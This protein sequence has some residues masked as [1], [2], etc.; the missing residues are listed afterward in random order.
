MCD[1]YRRETVFL[2]DRRRL[3]ISLRSQTEPIRVVLLSG[4]EGAGSTR[5]RFMLGSG[6]STQCRKIVYFQSFE[7]R[8][9]LCIYLPSV[10]LQKNINLKN[11]ESV[12]NAVTNVKYWLTRVPVS[13]YCSFSKHQSI[14]LKRNDALSF[15]VRLTNSCNWEMVGK[16]N[17][18]K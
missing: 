14:S 17:A 6:L 13:Y 1:C 16:R 10:P 4:K 8:K 15:V 3:F 2:K 5:K 11:G 7:L 12:F 9:D 18:N